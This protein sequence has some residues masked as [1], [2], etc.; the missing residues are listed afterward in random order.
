MV[1]T[2][3]CHD[4]RRPPSSDRA[5]GLPKL[6]RWEIIVHEASSRRIAFGPPLSHSRLH[7]VRDGESIRRWCDRYFGIRRAR[8]QASEAVS[9]QATSERHAVWTVTVSLSAWAPTKSSFEEPAAQA[10]AICPVRLSSLDSS[11]ASH[12]A[13]GLGYLLSRAP[14]WSCCEEPTA[15]P[16]SKMLRASGSNR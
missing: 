11:N 10:R 3:A 14:L 1:G 4:E 9:V 5:T 15:R 7:H 13:R 12:S 8:R 6:A 2:T 16:A